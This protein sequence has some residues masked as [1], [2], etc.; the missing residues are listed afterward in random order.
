M[1]QNEQGIDCGGV[2]QLVCS[3]NIKPLIPLWTRPVKISGDVYSVVS[4]I[5][6]QNIGNGVNA[7]IHIM[8][9]KPIRGWVRI[10]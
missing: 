8:D 9:K 6:N 5:E 7:L 1:N 4:Y 2:C 3:A 10:N